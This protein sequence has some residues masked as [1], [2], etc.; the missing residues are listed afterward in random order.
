MQG[1]SFLTKEDFYKEYE[2]IRREVDPNISNKQLMN[3]TKALFILVPWEKMEMWVREPN[4]RKTPAGEDNKKPNLAEVDIR[5]L[6]QLHGVDAYT[7]KEFGKMSRE[8]KQSGNT[9]YFAEPEIS[10]KCL[11]TADPLKLVEAMRHA[12]LHRLYVDETLGR[13]GTAVPGVVESRSKPIRE[14]DRQRSVANV[15]TYKMFPPHPPG[16][17]NCNSGTATILRM[18]GVAEQDI[19]PASEMAFGVRQRLAVWDPLQGHDISHELNNR[20]PN[21]SVD[22][23]S[24]RSQPIRTAE[25]EKIIREGGG[26]IGRYK[27]EAPA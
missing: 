18:A 26:N 1:Q 23:A 6:E 20:P 13:N 15:P 4:G 8:E 7:G 17:G 10:L 22:T 19:K 21:D 14:I 27:G 3:E 16:T 11:P 25:L 12:K 2:N 5:S 24:I 9:I